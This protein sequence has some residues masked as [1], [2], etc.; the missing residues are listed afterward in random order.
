M[1]KHTLVSK[2]ITR[3][4]I[5]DLENSPSLGWF[6]D[7]RKEN[8]IVAIQEEWFLLSFAYRWLDEN[9]THVYALPDFKRYKKDKKDDEQLVHKLHEVLSQADMLIAHNLDN[10][11]LKKANARFLIHGLDPIPYNKNLDTLKVARRNFKFNS[12]SNSRL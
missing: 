8:N 4:L 11:D 10:F 7:S 5:F 2:D 3:I 1:K 9:K 6:Y 12:N